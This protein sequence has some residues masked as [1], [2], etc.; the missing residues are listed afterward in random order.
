[1]YFRSALSCLV[2]KELLVADRL[3]GEV[4]TVVVLVAVS[5]DLLLQAV[6]IDRIERIIR[7]LGNSIIFCL[8]AE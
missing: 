5:A 1:M 8:V 2:S 6:S 3:A 7:I 4:S